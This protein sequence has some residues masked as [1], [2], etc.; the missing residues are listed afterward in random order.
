APVDAPASASAAFDI[1]PA[2]AWIVVEVANHSVE[3]CFVVVEKEL[4]AKAG[5]ARARRGWHVEG[6]LELTKRSDARK[7]DVGAPNER[8]KGR[9]AAELRAASDGADPDVAAV[10]GAELGRHEAALPD[11][12]VRGWIGI[13]L[14]AFIAQPTYTARRAKSDV[15][16][17]FSRE[18]PGSSTVAL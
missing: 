4:P 11:R 5:F 9:E 1:T 12:A 17:V 7:L 14:E 8:S 10:L 15:A 18:D 6:A 2:E 3:V 13:V 16:V